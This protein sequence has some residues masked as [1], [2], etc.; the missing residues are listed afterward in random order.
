MSGAASAHNLR[1]NAYAVVSNSKGETVTAVS[2]VN[3]DSIGFGMLKRV[4]QRLA[5]NTVDLVTDDR[6]QGLSSSFDQQAD[7]NRGILGQAVAE[8]RQAA[9]Q[10]IDRCIL[11]SKIPDPLAALQEHCVGAIQY[12]FQLLARLF[13]LHFRHHC[14]KA[15]NQALEALQKGIV[16]L[17]SDTLTLRQARAESF[18]QVRSNLFESKEVQ[19]KEYR[20]DR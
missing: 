9:G 14:L 5:P 15:Q 20:S 7:E 11:R 1:V 19:R 6:I 18:T 13:I 4:G 3:L 2:E 8:I 16:K 10:L 17:A 12:R